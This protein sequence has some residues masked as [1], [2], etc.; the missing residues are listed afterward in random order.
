MYRDLPRWPREAFLGAFLSQLV[1]SCF[2]LIIFL[3]IVSCCFVFFSLGSLVYLE[4]IRRDNPRF[5]SMKRKEFLASVETNRQAWEAI[6]VKSNNS[7]PLDAIEFD[8]QWSNRVAGGFN[9]WAIHSVIV[10]SDFVLQ[11]VWVIRR[12]IDCL[13]RRII[14]L[15]CRSCVFSFFII[16]T[17]HHQRRP[18]EFFFGSLSIWQRKSILS[19]VSGRRL[20]WSSFALLTNS[21]AKLGFSHSTFSKSFYRSGLVP[22]FQKWNE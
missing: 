18:F 2:A 1:K 9:D 16:P 4:V 3:Q 10:Q 7:E 21:L 20:R 14:Q 17:R 13:L 5:G 22:D 15:N 11:K 12:T 19:Q 6:L 8:I